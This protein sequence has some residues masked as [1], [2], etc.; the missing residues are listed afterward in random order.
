MTISF[1]HHEKKEQH[2]IDQM[3]VCRIAP[4]DI[5]LFNKLL[6]GYDNLTLVTTLDA[7]IGRMALR[8]AQTAKKDLMAVLHCLPVPVAFES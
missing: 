4:E 7:S 3:L 1:H 2:D 6:E 8:F 5:D